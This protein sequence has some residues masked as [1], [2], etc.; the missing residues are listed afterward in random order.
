MK[1]LTALILALIMA[2]SLCACGG[3][4]QKIELTT[5]NITD[6]LT[7]TV[8]VTECKV[9]KDS[10]NILGMSIPDITGK[11]ELEISTIA[12]SDINFE[13]VEITLNLEP[14]NIRWKFVRDNK[15]R[16]S[17]SGELEQTINYKEKR[18]SIPFDGEVEIADELELDTDESFGMFD[19]SLVTWEVIDVSG[20]VII[21]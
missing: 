14:A 16:T 13:D 19:L 1:R 18:I 5:D 21:N 6:Y 15:Q 17:T 12:Q 9:D 10:T 8:D 11:A 20:Y 7:I 3:G 2:L 4:E